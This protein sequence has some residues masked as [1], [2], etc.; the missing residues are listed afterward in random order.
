MGDN[1]TVRLDLDNEPKPDALLRIDETCGGQS[2][3]SEDD[4]IEGAPELIVEV[5]ASSA[6][7]DVHDKLQAYRRNGV[8]EY[9]VWLVQEGQ[10]RW[11]GLQEGEYRLQA[12]DEVGVLRNQV[13]PGL[14]LAVHALLSGDMQQVLAVS[15]K[16]IDSEAHQDFVAQLKLRS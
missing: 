3:I 14:Q 15:Q 2:H 13:F 6:S 5:A 16:G 12:P 7:Y 4:Y 10:F 8:K 1:P 9:L 11:Y